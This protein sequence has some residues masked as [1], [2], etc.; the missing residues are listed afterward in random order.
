MSKRPAI[1]PAFIRALMIVVVVVSASMFVVPFLHQTN[2]RPS[3]LSSKREALRRMRGNL[4]AL[5]ADYD[6]K[7]P[8]IQQIETAAHGNDENSVQLKKIVD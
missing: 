6:N 7:V 1:R 8:T 4:L 2:H 3:E 5:S